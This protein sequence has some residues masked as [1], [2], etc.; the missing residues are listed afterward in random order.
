M[1]N[2]QT[3]VSVRYNISHNPFPYS[4]SM[5]DIDLP[6]TKHKDALLWI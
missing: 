6:E 5:A 4:R 3:Y 2:R 1:F